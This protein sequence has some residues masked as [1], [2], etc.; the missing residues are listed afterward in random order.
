MTQNVFSREI[1][2]SSLHSTVDG[3]SKLPFSLKFFKFKLSE[4]YCL[5]SVEKCL[6]MSTN[7][8]SLGSVIL[9]ITPVI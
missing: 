7:K 6:Q 5:D 9:E 3:R 4:L 2:L 1:T 8:P